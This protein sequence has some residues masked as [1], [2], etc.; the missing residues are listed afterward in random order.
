MKKT[1]L[2]TFFTTKLPA[3]IKKAPRVTWNYIKAAKVELIVLAAVLAL[4]LLVKGIMQLTMDYGDRITVI[5]GFFYFH[6]LINLGAAGGFTFWIYSNA[7]RRIFFIIFTWIAVI[8]FTVAMVKFRKGHWLA[9]VCFAL[10]I[11]GALGNLFDRMF[12]TNPRG[13]FGVRD[14]FGFVLGGWN[15]PI[16]NIADV[17]LVG[18]VAVFAIYFIFMFKPAP[19][20]LIGPV[21]VDT[22][23]EG[24]V[25]IDNKPEPIGA[26]GCRPLPIEESVID[27][28][29]EK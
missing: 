5:S 19:P 4:D 9:R 6:Y 20:P 1:M 13:Y 21:W 22:A 29:I 24:A 3:G 7:G 26:A 14:M 17:A 10:I 2:K 16:F 8:A 25:S 27:S 11:A 15:A 12:I 18:G 23:V 28:K